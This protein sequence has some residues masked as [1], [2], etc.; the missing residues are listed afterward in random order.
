MAKTHFDSDYETV[1]DVDAYLNLLFT[2]VYT[3]GGGGPGDGNYL[4]CL[5]IDFFKKATFTGNR[6]LEIGSGPT[7]HNLIPASAYFKEITVAEFSKPC[8]DAVEKWIRAEPDAFD[9]SHFFDYVCAK[10]GNGESWKSRQ[11]NLRKYIKGVIPCDVHESN[12]LG[13][14]SLDPFDAIITSTCLEAA[15]LDN[16]SYRSAIKNITKLLKPGGLLL[17]WSTLNE[18]F[19]MI[20]GSRFHALPLDAEFIINAVKEAGYTDIKTTK[21]PVPPFEGIEKIADAEGILFLTACK[22]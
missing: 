17:I 11:E 18:S 5:Q 19:Y 21:F 4:L 14:N 9:W 8:R 15:C 22:L 16:Q 12:P 2:D 7:V 20:G 13:L 1:F 3:C 10:E 6:L